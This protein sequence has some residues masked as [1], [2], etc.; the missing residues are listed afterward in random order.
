MTDGFFGLQCLLLEGESDPALF[1]LDAEPGSAWIISRSVLQKA[2]QILQ[3][4]TAIS[5]QIISG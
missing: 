3:P 5:L 2:L 1:G 4:V